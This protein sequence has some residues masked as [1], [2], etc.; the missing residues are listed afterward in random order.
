MLENSLHRN[1]ALSVKDVTSSISDIGI[2]DKGSQLQITC[3]A[4]GN[5]RPHEVA[6]KKSNI[7]MISWASPA[8]D[9]TVLPMYYEFKCVYD[10]GIIGKTLYE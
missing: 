5:R 2:V 10:V 7:T 1:M 4:E 9:C 3:F 8:S 6:L